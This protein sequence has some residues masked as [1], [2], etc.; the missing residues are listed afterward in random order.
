MDLC[1]SAEHKVGT[2]RR[3]FHF[4][5]EEVQREMLQT[6]YP[7]NFRISTVFTASL[8]T[9][10]IPYLSISFPS[11]SNSG[12]QQVPVTLYRCTESGLRVAAAQEGGRVPG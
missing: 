12:F 2:F 10:I 4:V 5:Y 3:Q 1:S 8:P 9:H 7:Y 11:V 6:A